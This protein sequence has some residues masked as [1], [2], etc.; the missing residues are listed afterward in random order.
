M[1]K[2]TLVLL[3]E[4][5]APD[6]TSHPRATL[7]PQVQPKKLAFSPQACSFGGSVGLISVWA[8]VLEEGLLW[9]GRARGGVGFQL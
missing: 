8:V 2:T 5:I 7:S 3:L 4:H 9:E 6:V 1:P